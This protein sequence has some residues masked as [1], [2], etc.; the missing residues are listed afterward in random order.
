MN[1]K[2]PKGC[3]NISLAVYLQEHA[4]GILS[5]IVTTLGFLGVGKVGYEI[6]NLIDR[7][8]EQIFE[9]A[10]GVNAFQAQG[11]INFDRIEQKFE[12]ESGKEEEEK[13]S[14]E[15]KLLKKIESKID[16]DEDVSTIARMALRLAKQ[17]DMKKEV[18]WL[19]KEVHGFRD[20][21]SSGVT[22]VE[23][24]S[25][26]YYKDYRKLSMKF[27]LMDDSGQI[28]ELPLEMYISQPLDMVESAVEKAE[29]DKIMM[30]APPMQVMVD[31]LGV[32]PGEKVPYITKVSELESL[33]DGARREINDF[34]SRAKEVQE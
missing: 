7:S 27:R 17:L 19:E 23:D 20:E 31:E 14:D 26:H 18:E 33:L 11:D 28:E 8:Q 32:N 9:D 34:V 12:E 5:L 24:T 21:E 1:I 4:I 2:I 15:R 30:K 3:E 29:S 10:E 16:S 25:A 13:T 6:K 22:E